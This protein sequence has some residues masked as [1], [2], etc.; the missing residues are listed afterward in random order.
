[1]T[2]E[3]HNWRGAVSE[4]TVIFL[5]SI[6]G[7]NKEDPALMAIRHSLTPTHLES[8]SK[9]FEAYLIAGSDESRLRLLVCLKRFRLHFPSWPSE[10]PERTSADAQSFPGAF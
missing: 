10:L 7:S 2:A 8:T 1:M 3:V 6:T 9:C 4:L 5:I